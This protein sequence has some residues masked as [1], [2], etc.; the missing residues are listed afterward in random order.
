[1]H[2]ARQ[3]TTLINPIAIIQHH[4]PIANEYHRKSKEKA[5]NDK[6]TVNKTDKL[7]N[8]RLSSTIDMHLAKGAIDIE[9]V[10]TITTTLLHFH[11]R[12]FIF[13]L[14]DYCLG[15]NLDFLN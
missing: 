15:L 7:D 10:T 4:L 1:M 13:G 11:F 9:Y 3:K 5:D 14:L 8:F 12:F 6:N 2:F